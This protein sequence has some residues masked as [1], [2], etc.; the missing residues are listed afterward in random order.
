VGPAALGTYLAP[1][2][3]VCKARVGKTGLLRK[4]S[5]TGSFQHNFHQ[6][7]G[8]SLKIP[9]LVTCRANRMIAKLLPE[10]CMGDLEYLTAGRCVLVDRPIRAA[11]VA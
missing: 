2:E 1:F 8:I 5:T 3:Q 9:C 11:S 10:G 4:S 6:I 7:D